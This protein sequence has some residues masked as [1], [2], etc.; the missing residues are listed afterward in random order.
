MSEAV[1]TMSE[2]ESKTGADGALEKGTT[3][4]PAQQEKTSQEVNAFTVV[5]SV[6]R[7]WFG[8]QTEENRQRDFN[9]NKPGAFI[10]AGIIFTVLM[11]IGVIIAVN[12]ALSG[13]GQ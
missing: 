4:A 6:F 10:A 8:V 12:I 2:Q 1:D 5:G 3:P 11:I 7:A 13:T 9:A